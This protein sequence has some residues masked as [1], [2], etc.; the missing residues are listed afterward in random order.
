MKLK[1][2]LT[3][4]LVLTL[5][6][7]SGLVFGESA[8][9]ATAYYIEVDI[10]NQIVTVYR[11]GDHTSSGIVRQ[12]ICSTGMSGHSTPT[13]TFT[14]P[15]K[16][17]SSERTEWYYF[18]S[19]DCWGKWA[20][21]IKGP[22]L[23]HSIPYS[24]KTSGPS[25]T[26]LAKLGSPAS[27]GCVRL[28][29]EDSKWIALNC[30]AGTK[31]KIYKSGNRD[32]ELRALLLERSFYIGNES[33]DE[34]L[35][36]ANALKKGD[37][38]ERVMQ[39]QARLNLLGYGAGTADGV[40][41]SATHNAVCAFQT[42]CGLSANGRV[43]ERVWDRIFAADAPCAPITAGSSGLHVQALQKAL[44]T[45]KLYD[46][47][48][49][50][51]YDDATAAAVKLYQSASGLT[52]DGKATSAV[53]KSILAR[54]D[55]VQAQ[56]GETDYQ[57]VIT[58]G[59]RAMAKVKVSSTLNLRKSASTSSKVL[60]KLKNGT[61][62]VVLQKSSSWS[63]VQYGS[64]VGYCKNSYLKFYTESTASLSYEPVP[65]PDP[66]ATPTPTPDP[67]ATP[68]PVA[69]DE[70]LTVGSTGTAVTNLQRALKELRLYEGDLT[71]DF[72]A[73]TADAVKT[74]QS[75]NGLAVDGKATPDTQAK[76]LDRAEA[77]RSQFYGDYY[78]ATVTTTSTDMAK[79]KV[80]STL[81]LRK[82]AST[83]SKVLAKL[84]NG[85]IVTV[86]DKSSSWSKVQYGST[87]GYCKNSY[88]KFFT[89]T[90]TAVT[91]EPL[92]TP[93][94]TATPE[95]TPAPEDTSAPEVSDTPDSSELPT[96]KPEST[97][98]PKPESSDDPD[99]QVT[100]APDSPVTDA[101]D[102][103]VTDAPDSKVTGAPD[104]G[105]TDAPDSQVTG[106]PDSQVTGAP[107]SQVTGAPDS[108]VTDAPDSKVTDAPEVTATS[109]VYAVIRD[110]DTKLYKSAEAKD[111]NVLAVESAGTFYEIITTD[112]TWTSVR[113][114]GGKTAWILT[115]AVRVT[116]DKPAATAAPSPAPAFTPAP[117]TAAA[118]ETPAVPDETP[119]GAADAGEN[120]SEN[121]EE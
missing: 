100:D 88:L 66:D 112:E 96:L 113:Y 50:G 99:S 111:D 26:A 115:E 30:P 68:R 45:L 90:S 61:V 62:V 47:E 1:R 74:F 118:E 16:S 23:F 87:V 58:T 106:A 94:P 12:M 116:A 75:A 28:R 20:T 25:K 15:A 56:F 2:L 86:L 39:L 53:Q 71:G 22:Y 80:S 54:A 84:K 98:T 19:Y 85:T 17:R 46:G 31:V 32:N 63:K 76:I 65:T 9:A 97:V 34:F 7:A 78:T 51:V 42:A 119:S 69:S 14:L 24:S 5:A 40:F 11:S 38:G 57:A 81:N 43:T 79:V 72:D 35:G 93:E 83:S 8:Q 37:S 33:Y 108:G 13:G 29:V 44:K 18:S 120:E 89:S 4:L 107:D 114:D 3:V 64:T 36:I 49:H 48:A 117:Q 21:R 60:A 101:P 41:G 67:N 104:S 73:A 6:A 59:S 77:V 10:T 70:T 92:P 102:S 27:H 121:P 55:E 82:S 103:G 110:D 52:A 109:P 91:Y 95:I 105:V